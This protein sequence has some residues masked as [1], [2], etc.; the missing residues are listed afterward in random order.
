MHRLLI[1]DPPASI[2]ETLRLDEDR[3]SRKTTKADRS[4]QEQRKPTIPQSKSHPHEG[5]TVSRVEISS[6]FSRGV[7][8]QAELRL[9]E[10]RC[11]NLLFPEARFAI[12]GK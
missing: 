5:N 6:L 2:G 10:E 4:H 9:R 3:L 11:F 7:R 12:F 8:L 1:D